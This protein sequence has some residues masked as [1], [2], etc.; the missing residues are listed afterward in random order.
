MLT[1][2][3]HKIEMV[4]AIECVLVLEIKNGLTSNNLRKERVSHDRCPCN[5][6]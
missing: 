5:T 6:C 1:S 2:M 3:G 4:N